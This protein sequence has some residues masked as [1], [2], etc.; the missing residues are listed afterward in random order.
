LTAQKPPA[1]VP[2]G[3][4]ADVPGG[5]ASAAQTPP[6]VPSAFLAVGVIASTHGIGG[7][8]KVK[9]YSGQIEHLLTLRSVT[10]KRGQVETPAEF[11]WV[12]R[13]DPGVIVKVA[14]LDTP[15][16]ARALVGSEIWVPRAAAAPLENEEYYAADLCR[17]RLW[18]GEEEVGTVRSVW[19]G[20]PAQ[21]LEVVGKEGKT[22]LVPFS[23]HFIGDVDLSSGTIRLKDDEI[24]R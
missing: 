3:F 7:E 16:K 21:L 15:E 22:F 19:E 18:F 6:P 2:G 13:Q 12:R 11:E 14:G 20:G 23:E 1:D 24:I 9:S 5:F 8:L 4:V 10:L 17:C